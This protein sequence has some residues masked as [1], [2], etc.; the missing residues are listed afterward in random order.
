[1][2]HVKVGDGQDES[3]QDEMEERGN[4]GGEPG[5][6]GGERDSHNDAGNGSRHI[7]A[8]KPCESASQAAIGHGDSTTYTPAGSQHQSKQ[9]KLDQQESGVMKVAALKRIECRKKR[10]RHPKLNGLPR[11]TQAEKPRQQ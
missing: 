1:M 7:Y 10:L 8:A 2:V 3:R 5:W 11:D 6:S 9:Q 4:P